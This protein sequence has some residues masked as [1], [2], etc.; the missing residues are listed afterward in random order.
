MRSKLN[1]E[2]SYLAYSGK[3]NNTQIWS[4]RKT[5]A[6]NRFNVKTWRELDLAILKEKKNPLIEKW[7]FYKRFNPKSIAT[8]SSNLLTQPHA[9]SKSTDF[10][11]LDLQHTSSHAYDFEIPLKDFR[12][13]LVDLVATRFH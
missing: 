4:P 7:S 6:T 5:N 10:S 1:D 2:R 13:P 9:S 12:S 3:V 8:S 11:L